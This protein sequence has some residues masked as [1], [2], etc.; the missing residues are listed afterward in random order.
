MDDDDKCYSADGIYINQT[1]GGGHF[2]S[3]YYCTCS[4]TDMCN[5]LTYEQMTSLAK[6]E[7]A[8]IKCED[9]PYQ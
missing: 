6:G 5:S 3:G 1:L 7:Y 2:T 8:N 9:Q 4:S